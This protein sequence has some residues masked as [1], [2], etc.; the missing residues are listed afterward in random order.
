[1]QIVLRGRWIKCEEGQKKD[2]VGDRKAL[3]AKEEN[4]RL[5]EKLKVQIVP[6]V[7]NEK[8][9]GRKENVKGRNK[10]FRGEIKGTSVNRTPVYTMPPDCFTVHM[11]RTQS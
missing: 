5:R 8:H 1:M 6:W 2:Y 4:E 3:R 10:G 7:K 11:H 9:E